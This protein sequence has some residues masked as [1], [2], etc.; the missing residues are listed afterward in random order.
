MRA[1][2]V[3]VGEL[4]GLQKP[5]QPVGRRD[6]KAVAIGSRTLM[7][8]AGG[9][10]VAALE[11]RAADAADLFAFRVEGVHEAVLDRSAS[12][13]KSGPPKLPDFNAR[14]NGAPG[15]ARRPASTAHPDRWPA[16]MRRRVTPKAC[17]TAPEVSP[18]GDDEAPHSGLDEAAGDL[19]KTVFDERPGPHGAEFRLDRL[20]S[21][22][23]AVA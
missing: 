22:A 3:G 4:I 11:E 7:L 21:A 6:Q 9:V 2:G 13:K 23:D 8:P 16:Q 18:P 10:H 17:T 5:R 19:R 14:C 15:G 20:Q 12:S 1:D